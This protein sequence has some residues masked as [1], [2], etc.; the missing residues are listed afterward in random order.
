MD[1]DDQIKVVRELATT[2]NANAEAAHKRIDAMLKEQ[3]ERATYGDPGKPIWQSTGAWNDLCRDRDLWKL[4]ATR[5]EAERD[6]WKGRAD[7]ILRLASGVNEWSTDLEAIT[8]A[9]SQFA[10]SS[11]S[12]RGVRAL[13]NRCVLVR[14]TDNDAPPG[15]IEGPEALWIIQRLR[16]I[17]AIP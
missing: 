1:I 12:V 14:F 4:R 15:R 13:S 3:G 10:Q 9:Q 8:R 5:L 2:A 6:E 7:E 17:G 16:E 11:L